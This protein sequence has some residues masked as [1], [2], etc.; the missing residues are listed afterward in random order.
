MGHYINP[1][2]SR[3]SPN[4]NKSEKLRRYDTTIIRRYDTTGCIKKCLI[5]VLAWNLFQ[6][7]DFTFQGYSRIRI[8]CLN[9]LG[10][11]ILPIK[12]LKCIWNTEIARADKQ[13]QQYIYKY[14][15]YMWIFQPKFK[16]P[17]FLRHFR[18][19]M[20]I[21]KVPRWFEHEILILKHPWKSKI[22]PL[23]QIL[24]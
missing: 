21:I 12:N 22:Q 19:L 9:H 4:K 20:S 17:A 24:G 1:S 23:E 2:H 7:S 14:V 15:D 5:A 3:A 8:S 6:G 16:F 18:F 10:T 13:K 11:L